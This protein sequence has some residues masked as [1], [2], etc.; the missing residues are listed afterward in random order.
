MNYLTDSDEHATMLDGKL[1]FHQEV[2]VLGHPI[3]FTDGNLNILEPTFGGVNLEDIAAPQ[4]RIN[5]FPF[6]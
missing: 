2:S 4:C 3:L 5:I 1:V 6:H